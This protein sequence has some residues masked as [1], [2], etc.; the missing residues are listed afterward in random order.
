MANPRYFN[1][2]ITS[3]Y[4]ALNFVPLNLFNQ[5]K[6]A[7]NVYFLLIGFMQTIPSIT[8]SNGQPV[9]ALPLTLVVIAS[10]LKDAFEDHKRHKS[11]KGENMKEC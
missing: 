10:M 4:T 6:K 1:T 3:K 11:D 8:I 5:F 9:M 7:A 2:I